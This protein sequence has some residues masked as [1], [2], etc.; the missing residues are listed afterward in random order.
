MFIKI[1]FFKYLRNVRIGINL[2]RKAIEL[3]ELDKKI[4]IEYGSFMYQIH[5]FCSRQ[6]KLDRHVSL[7]NADHRHF[8]TNQLEEKKLEFLN[9]AIEAYETLNN[10]SSSTTDTEES[11]Q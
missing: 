2:F 5:A 4:L 10:S 6:L 3:I 8:I 11:P 7:F 9:F 1:F